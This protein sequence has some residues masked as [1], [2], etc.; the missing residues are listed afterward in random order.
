MEPYKEKR[1]VYH[2]FDFDRL[3]IADF[4]DQDQELTLDFIAYKTES[5][6]N[7]EG[8]VLVRQMKSELLIAKRKFTGA[9]RETIKHGLAENINPFA[10]E[11]LAEIINNCVEHYKDLLQMQQYSRQEDDK[12]NLSVSKTSPKFDRPGPTKAREQIII[13][14]YLFKYLNIKVNEVFSIE[15]KEIIKLLSFITSRHPDQVNDALKEIG[16]F[17]INSIIHKDMSNVKEYFTGLGLEKISDLIDQ[18]LNS[19]KKK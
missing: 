16:S 5:L 1:P 19:L 15:Q 12:N 14:Q 2:Y 9:T 4:Y 17:R 11:D 13:L 7:Y 18:D 10:Y 3:T 8:F 6:S